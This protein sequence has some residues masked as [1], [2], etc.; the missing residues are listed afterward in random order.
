[1]AGVWGDFPPFGGNPK[2]S[3][4][5]ANR[6]RWRRRI[7]WAILGTLVTVVVA[8]ATYEVQRRWDNITHSPNGWFSGLGPGLQR[9]LHAQEAGGATA[10]AAATVAATQPGGSLTLAGL[11]TRLPKY[12]WVD[13]ATNVPYSA[14]RPIVGIA[15]SGT[16]IE[17]AVEVDG[18]C[19]FGLT[20]T[21]STDPLTDED[22]VAGIGRY[23]HL[24]GP[25]TYY[26]TVYHAPQC[27]A[28]RAPS[29]GWTSWP[30]AFGSF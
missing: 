26:Q 1:M 22:H 13:D 29:S 20:I 8:G 15:T 10:N 21:S 28:D 9:A 3:V 23:Y 2:T 7:A 16:H 12:Q 25:G 6:H 19:S 18:L 14:K 30:N 17:T 24:V 4:G 27:A 5:H 11:N